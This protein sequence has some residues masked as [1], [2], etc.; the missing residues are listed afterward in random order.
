MK[1]LKIWCTQIN[2]YKYLSANIAFLAFKIT[3]QNLLFFSLQ[4]I[5]NV[6]LKINERI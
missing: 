2:I 6:E 4:K 1:K 3:V 5:S